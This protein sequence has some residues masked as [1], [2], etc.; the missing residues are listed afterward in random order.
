MMVGYTQNYAGDCYK[1]YSPDTSRIHTARDVKWLNRLYYKNMRF[2]T[3]E[4][5][6]TLESG[7]GEK[8]TPYIAVEESDTSSDDDMLD[9]VE[10]NELGFR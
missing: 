1:M 9:T 8:D 6:K 2:Y 10:P 3:S 4:D 5:L 7:K